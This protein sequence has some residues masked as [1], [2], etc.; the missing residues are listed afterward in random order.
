ML[1]WEIQ[2]SRVAWVTGGVPG[3][4]FFWKLLTVALIHGRPAA[5]N[6]TDRDNVC[7]GPDCSGTLG[8]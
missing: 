5:C 2:Y 4:D 3:T 6:G 8:S 7:T 1:L